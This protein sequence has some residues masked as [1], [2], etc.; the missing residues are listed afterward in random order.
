MPLSEKGVTSILNSDIEWFDK[1]VRSTLAITFGK[2][3]I[4]LS[5]FLTYRLKNENVSHVEIGFDKNNNKIIVKPATKGLKLFL[6][7]KT[8]TVSK[9]KQFISYLKEKDIEGK[10]ELI[11]NEKQKWYE[12]KEE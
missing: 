5:K 10:Y 4:Y 2:S 11:Y 7:N 12:S 9:P 3:N 8:G 1:D 6:K